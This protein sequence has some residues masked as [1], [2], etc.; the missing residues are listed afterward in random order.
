MSVRYIALP[1]LYMN[2]GFTLIEVLVSVSILV[3]VLAFLD[4]A[5]RSLPV[6]RVAAHREIALA[7]AAQELEQVRADTYAAL[8]P[9][10]SFSDPQLSALPDASS[11]IAVTSFNAG[12]KQVVVTVTWQEEYFGTSTI[13]LATLITQ[14]GL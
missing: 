14:G 6:I 1:S 8:P 2:R 7:A 5:I 12:T 4:A 9:S 11:S 13:A 3:A 10:G